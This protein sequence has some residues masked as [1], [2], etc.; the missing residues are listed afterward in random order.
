MEQVGVVEDLGDHDEPFPG[1]DVDA[2]LLHKAKG[3]TFGMETLE[4]FE[5]T[6]D[7]F[8]EAPDPTQI[9]GMPDAG[10]DAS[11]G[12]FYSIGGVGS[13]VIGSYG[14]QNI[15]AGDTIDV[16]ELGSTECGEFDDEPYAVGVA[17][18]ADGNQFIEIG[19]ASGSA[20]ML[21]SQLP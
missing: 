9:L 13:Y 18:S 10:C 6:F 7:G 11:S 3:G 20:A 5:T 15:E 12:R 14:D 8:S 19:T 1:A 2:V 17:I 16:I 21:I 4:D